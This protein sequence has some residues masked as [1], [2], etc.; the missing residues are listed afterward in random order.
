[1]TIAVLASLSFANPLTMFDAQF[2]IT[3]AKSTYCKRT[4]SVGAFRH[5]LSCACEHVCLFSSGL[6]YGSRRSV[7]NAVAQPIL[8]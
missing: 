7:A 1:M 2:N 3:L 6:G 5:R 4:L 8:C